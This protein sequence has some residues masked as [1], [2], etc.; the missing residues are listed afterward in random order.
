M[1]TR[2]W[3]LTLSVA[4]GLLLTGCGQEEMTAFQTVSSG[5]YQITLLAPG[6]VLKSGENTIAVQ[7][8]QNGQP[9][10]VE[11]AELM[12]SM[13]QMGAMPY[14]ETRAQFAQ[15]VD[16]ATVD[17]TITFNMGGSWNGNVQVT[18]PG[19]PAGGTFQLHVEERE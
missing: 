9:V 11:Q 1:K 8:S 6:G 2:H 14:M 13:P 5:P 10:D 18:T 12:F 3:F 4:F 16:A 15:P 7:V 17:G 19:G